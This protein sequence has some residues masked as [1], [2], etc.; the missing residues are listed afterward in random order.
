VGKNATS[1]ATQ[2]TFRMI[3]TWVHSIPA[4]A[5]ITSCTLYVA[6]T[7]TSN[8]P[9]ADP[10]Y[11]EFQFK[12]F[13][14]NKYSSTPAD[15]WAA[16]TT[17]NVLR[18]E[19]TPRSPGNYYTQFTMD[20]TF[21][22]YI[23]N[24][25]STGKFHLAFRAT[26]EETFGTNRNIHLIDFK[27]TPTHNVLSAVRIVITY[28]IPASSVNM[29]VQ[30]NFPGGTIF[31]DSEEKV[32]PFYPFTKLTGTTATLKAKEQND[33]LGYTRIWN[34]I[35]APLNKSIWLRN[36]AD[37]GS[38]IEKSFVV[39][40]SDDGKTYEAGLRKNYRIDQTH[41]FEFGADILQ[42]NPGYIVEQN[43]GTIT[44]PLNSSSGNKTGTFS[45]WTDGVT[46]RTRN[47]TFPTDNLTYTAFYK[48]NNYASATTSYDK[49]GQKK[50]LMPWAAYDSGNWKVYESSGQIWLEKNGVVVNGGLPVNNLA[51]GPEAKSPAMDYVVLS[52]WYS[53]IFVV[54]QQ[55]TSNGK[56]KIKLAKFNGYGQKIYSYDVLTSTIDYS[57]FDATPVIS[58]A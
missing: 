4:T 55:K 18:T 8:A 34:D 39:A 17:S 50:F 30:N 28:T 21:L 31:A 11:V 44:T 43:S 48:L 38:T 24:T 5:T 23:K 37:V 57:V 22:N 2:N 25:L 51:D 54:Y 3:Y 52:N 13:P 32:S 29:T 56:Y 27:R 46:T 45:F 33:N 26:D 6:Q 15:Q 19:Q 41:K 14:N 47:V 58:A 36:G 16:I 49:D 9:T 40:Q 20:Q 42:P 35:E 1:S 7:V 53:D 10:P 12:E